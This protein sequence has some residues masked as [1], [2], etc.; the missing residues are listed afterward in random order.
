MDEPQLTAAEVKEIYRAKKRAQ[1]QQNQL[2]VNK[3]KK[4]VERKIT[5]A[6][7]VEQIEQIQPP[8]NKL[9]KKL[10][11]NPIGVALNALS[12][13][14]NEVYTYECP[15]FAT[16]NRLSRGGVDSDNKALFYV[17]LPSL[18]KPRKWVKRSVAL[19]ME[20]ATTGVYEE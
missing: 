7:K 1:R 10:T 6:I 20:P 3:I 8:S 16:T 18:V 2:A 9:G 17:Q 13:K 14:K 5:E 11:M 4:A 15:V 12:L 19:L